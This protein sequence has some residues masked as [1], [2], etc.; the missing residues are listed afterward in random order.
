MCFS[1]SPTRLVGNRFDLVPIEILAIYAVRER[2]ELSTAQIDHSLLSQA[3]AC[4]EKVS[5][6]D[7][8]ITQGIAELLDDTFGKDGAPTPP[9]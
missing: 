5:F 3:M 1:T 4:A 8:E 2:L 6:H 7:D 9:R